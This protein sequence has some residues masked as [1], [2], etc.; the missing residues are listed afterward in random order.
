M[1]PWWRER[2]PAELGPLEVRLGRV[3]RGS[4][5]AAVSAA[6]RQLAPSGDP[7]D[8]RAALA[9]LDELLVALKPAAG[10]GLE[11]RLSNQFVRYSMLPWSDELRS[12]AEV[13][14]FARHRLRETYGGV[15]DDWAVSLSA[16][17]PG[18]PRL[19][20]AIEQSLLDALAALAQ[21]TRLKLASIEPRFS[22]LADRRRRALKGARFW[23]AQSESG[24]IVLARADKG[25][26]ESL[27][28]ARDG[29]APVTALLSLLAAERFAMDDDQASRRLYCDGFPAG[30]EAAL[31]AAGWEIVP[32]Q[33]R[34]AAAM[35]AA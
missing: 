28:S 20:G 27:V 29:G 14:A 30:D 1:S 25:Q 24:R 31:A 4:R 19:A 5:K 15:A 16:G 17:W 26:W 18:K 13:H 11:V 22:A 10:A 8:W 7:Q 32:A 35:A 6:Q 9:A 21:R 34:E 12:E 3:S 2:L 33:P 23:L